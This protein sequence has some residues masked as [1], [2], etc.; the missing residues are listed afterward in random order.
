LEN[1]MFAT[2][3]GRKVKV[4][5]LG[6]SCSIWP[7]RL[8]TSYCGSVEYAAPEVLLRQVPPSSHA[9]PHRH[10]RHRTRTHD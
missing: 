1:V 3:G 2:P 6:L 7:G 8:L 4:I 9:P 5:D 10:T